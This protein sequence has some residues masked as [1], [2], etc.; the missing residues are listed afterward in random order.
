MTF[1]L[2]VSPLNALM[3]DEI[4]KLQNVHVQTSTV[5]ASESISIA[6]IQGEQGFVDNLQ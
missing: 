5:C 2:V 4:I 6:N 1:I 3:P